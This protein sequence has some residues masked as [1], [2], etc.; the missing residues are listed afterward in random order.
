MV[1][2]LNLWCRSDADQS[3]RREFERAF[4]NLNAGNFHWQLLDDLADEK[5]DTEGGLITAPGFILLSQGMIAGRCLTGMDVAERF[6]ETAVGEL[7]S[8]VQ[9]SELLCDRFESSSLCD[10]YRH[11]FADLESDSSVQSDSLQNAVRCALANCADDLVLPLWELCSLREEQA[12]HY[13]AAMKDRDWA[14]ARRCLFASKA[15]FRILLATQEESAREFAK[16]E[17]HQIRDTSL[18]KILR[19]IEMLTMHCY[20][21][22]RRAA[23]QDT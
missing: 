5:T 23:L 15:G 11:S 18:L 10:R 9:R 14:A 2:P 13:L 4:F 1:A 21:K 20:G 17:L 12:R 6:C 22:A 16:D 7:K 8:A 19:I 3:R